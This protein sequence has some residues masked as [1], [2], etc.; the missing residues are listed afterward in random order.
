MED[1]AETISAAVRLH[2]QGQL[3]QAEALYRR[4][5]EQEPEHPGALHLLGVVAH[6]QGHD[7]RAAELIARAL[8]LRPDQATYHSNYGVAP[9]PAHIKH[10]VET[11]LV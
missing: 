3:A 7:D 10:A 2:Q 5:L 8:A 9:R 4:I 6:Q 1:L 11:G